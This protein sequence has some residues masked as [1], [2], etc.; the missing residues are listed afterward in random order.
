MQTITLTARVNVQPGTELENCAEVSTTT[1]ERNTGNNRG[2]DRR[3]VVPDEVDLRV[4][5]GANPG[6]P[7]PGNEYVYW[8]SFNNDRPASALNVRITD[9]LPVSVTFVS[10]WHRAGWSVDTSTPGVVVWTR[11]E[12]PGWYGEYMELKVRVNTDVPVETQLRN[13]VESGVAHQQSGRLLNS[14]LPT[15]TATMP[16]RGGLWRGGIFNCGGKLPLFCLRRHVQHAFRAS[17]H[18]GVPHRDPFESSLAC[19]APGVRPRFAQGGA[20]SPQ[21]ALITP[22]QKEPGAPPAVGLGAAAVGGSDQVEPR[23]IGRGGR[24]RLIE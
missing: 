4:N 14:P 17:H 20:V 19:P 12:F 15:C 13:H 9:T 3:S 2:C 21:V 11:A 18:H 8:I 5:K 24:L 1:W 10:E 22:A 7:A 23:H 6:D 16:T